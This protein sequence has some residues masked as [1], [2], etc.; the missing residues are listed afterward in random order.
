MY[1]LSFMP[2][3]S[4]ALASSSGL[5]TARPIT[6]TCHDQ[7]GQSS[8]VSVVASWTPAPSDAGVSAPGAN[9]G[10]EGG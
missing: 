5:E 6:L 7:F 9:D 8:L 3:V 2:G 4:D 10:G 1:S